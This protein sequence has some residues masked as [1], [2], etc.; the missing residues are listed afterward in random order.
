MVQYVLFCY[1][2]ACQPLGHMYRVTT[3]C[4]H[5]MLTRHDIV[6]WYIGWIL[7]KTSETAIPFKTAKQFYSCLC[8]I[9]LLSGTYYL[10]TLLSGIYY[11]PTLL[12]DIY[13]NPR[14]FTNS[15]G[16]VSS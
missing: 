10:P 1:D 9:I 2:C 12:S 3:S 5:T 7:M 4:L 11:L 14:D 15:V 6:T 16:K 8:T 13:A